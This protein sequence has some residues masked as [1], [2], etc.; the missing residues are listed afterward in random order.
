MKYLQRIVSSLNEIRYMD[1]CIIPM[2]PYIG[3]YSLYALMQVI[4]FALF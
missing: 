4:F 1:D 2:I 3:W